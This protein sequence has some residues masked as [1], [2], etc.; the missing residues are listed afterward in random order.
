[1]SGEKPKNWMLEQFREV[2]RE[3][4]TWPRW[5]RVAAELEQPKKCKTCGRENDER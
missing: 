1:M 2:V 3:C 4:K 5:M